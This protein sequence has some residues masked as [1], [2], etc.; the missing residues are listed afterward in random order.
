MTN[1]PGRWVWR[2][3]SYSQ[4]TN[5]TD[6]VEVGHWRKASYSNGNSSCV[7]V[8][9]AS[10][11]TAVRDSKNPDAGMLAVPASAWRAFRVTV[12]E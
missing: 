10:G 9:W 3:S 12:T 5:N 6:C 2:K 1:S 11:T 4:G 8:G 7:E